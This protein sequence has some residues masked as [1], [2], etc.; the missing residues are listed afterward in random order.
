MKKYEFFNAETGI[1]YSDEFNEEVSKMF[2]DHPVLDE[3]LHIDSYLLYLMANDI[4]SGKIKDWDSREELVS[5][6]R[7]WNLPELQLRINRAIMQ[8][9]QNAG[10]A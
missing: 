3:L 10:G 1:P 6:M 2:D 8:L 7:D 5:C 4:L 9:T